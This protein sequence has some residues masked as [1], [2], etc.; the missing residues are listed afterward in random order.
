MSNFINMIFY[1]KDNTNYTL[2]IKQLQISF[3]YLV[4]IKEEQN[5][6]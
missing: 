4:T 2:M 3:V 1:F 6:G 5:H